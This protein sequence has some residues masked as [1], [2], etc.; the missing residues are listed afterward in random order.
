MF[1][2]SRQDCWK[3]LWNSRT[4]YCIQANVS[5]VGC[6]EPEFYDAF[7]PMYE[8][9]FEVNLPGIGRTDIDKVMATIAGVAA[10]GIGLD[11]IISR[12]TR[13]WETSEEEES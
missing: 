10:G 1:Q 12:A 6:S 2:P 13:R 5:C 8:H 4:N 7:S 9:Q 3:R 11:M